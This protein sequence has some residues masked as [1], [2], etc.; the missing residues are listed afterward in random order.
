MCAAAFA[1]AR[2]TERDA[3]LDETGL[4]LVAVGGYGRGELAPYSDLDVVLLHADNRKVDGVASTIW[5]PLWDSTFSVDHSLRAESEVAETAMSDVR[6]HMG[7][8]DIRHV[9]GDP[10]LTMR[11]RSRI[12][13]QW[14]HDAHRLLPEVEAASI[15]RA[16]RNGELGHASVPDLKESGGGLRDATA[17][18]AL[19]MS[20]LVDVPHAELE[21]CRQ[22]LL[23]VRDVV[24]GLA[25]RASDQVVPEMWAPLAEG[26]GLES[27]EAAQRLVRAAGRRIT[28]ISRLM[29]HRVDAVLNRPK[30]V[31]RRA[32][33]LERVAPGVAI[34]SGEVVLDRLADPAKDPLLLLRAA[35]EA[36]ERSLHL[37]PVTAARLGASGQMPEEPWDEETR[38]LF[39]RFIAGGPGLLTVWETLEETGALAK[40]LPEWEGVRLLPH[41][42][43]VHRFTVDRHMVETAIEASRMIR[44]VARPDILMVASLLHDIGKATT[45]DHSVAGAPLV[46]AA[47]RRMGF[48]EDDSETIARLVRW[49]LLLPTV[50]TSRDLNDPATASYVAE[51]VGSKETLD[52]LAVLTEAD[53]RATG[54]QAWTAWRASLVKELARRTRAVLAGEPLEVDEH[55]RVVV[56]AGVA[57]GDTYVTVESTET[58]ARAVVVAPDRVGQLLTVAG[59]LTLM[60]V[61][62]LAAHSWTQDGYA[63]SEWDLDETVDAGLLKQRIDAVA[64]GTLDPQSRIGDAPT[65]PDPVVVLRDDL[66]E[67]ASVIEVRTG[68]RVGLLFLVFRALATLG[69]TVRSA[70]L[71]TLGPQ[72]MDVFYV[73]HADAGGPLAPDEAE[74]ALLAV[75]AALTH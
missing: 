48:D 26:L 9:A 74:A 39:V 62:V 34:S 44:R 73:E 47:A 75:G 8:L 37:N 59:A 10:A 19:V 27:A 68:D 43:A 70:H 5:Y 52:L 53:A 72:T 7:L 6:V 14:R 56:P 36:S 2:A 40:L 42:S 58:G 15:T 49:H 32:P 71:S 11:V 46:Q 54:P 3:G 30:V 33:K 55:T 25:G 13:T 29:W 61:S 28:H 1:A 18:N 69:L 23:D 24:H 51:R 45:A 38:N 66:S 31:L 21:R 64:D 22:Q 50:A 67:D 60:R 4:A 57:A 20:W 41:A 65:G 63:V 16:E 12:L 17:L 35:A